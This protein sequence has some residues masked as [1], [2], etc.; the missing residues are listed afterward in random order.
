MDD[1]QQ[2][3][4]EAQKRSLGGVFFFFLPSCSAGLLEIQELVFLSEAD[5]DLVMQSVSVYFLMFC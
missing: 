5:S 1:A 3:L 4:Q 2:P